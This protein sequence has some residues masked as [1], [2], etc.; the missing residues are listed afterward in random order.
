MMMNCLYGMVDQQKAFCLICNRDHCQGSSPSRISDT[1]QTGFETL[2][3]LN[4]GLV[5]WSCEVVMTTTPHRSD[6]RTFWEK[7]DYC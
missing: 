6:Y 3:N 1:S 2:Q 5:K 7:F 4:S